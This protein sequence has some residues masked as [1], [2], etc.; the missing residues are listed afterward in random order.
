MLLVILPTS[1]CFLIPTLQDGILESAPF[2][3]LAPAFISQNSA[4]KI[5]GS[6]MIQITGIPEKAQRDSQCNLVRLVFR[7]LT[8]K[9]FRCLPHHDMCSEARYN[10]SAGG[11]GDWR[12]FGTS[13]SLSSCDLLIEA[14]SRRRS[15]K[16]RVFGIVLQI[17]GLR[18]KLRPWLCRRGI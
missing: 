5:P 3:S 4:G 1:H 14:G 2:R 10:F 18:G 8:L 9:R 11:T 15:D 13:G 17:R 16:G 7:P 6:Q 12:H